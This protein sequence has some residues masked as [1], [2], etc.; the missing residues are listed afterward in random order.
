MKPTATGSRLLRRARSRLYTGPL[1]RIVRQLGLDEYL[2][3]PYWK[4]VFTLADDTQTRSIADQTVSFHAAT[5]DE[6]MKFRNLAGERPILKDLLQSLKPD[7]V[8]YDIGANVSTYT[9]FCSVDARTERCHRLR[10]GAEERNMAEREPR[11][12]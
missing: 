1:Q 2:S 7:D 8:F 9:S 11:P 10:T 12:E 6:F 4:L 3:G 5:F